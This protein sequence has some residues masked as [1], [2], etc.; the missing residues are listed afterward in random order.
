[1]RKIFFISLF[2][3]FILPLLHSQSY[4]EKHFGATINLRLN[5]GTHINSLGLGVSGYWQDFFVQ[6]NIQSNISFRLN[7]LGKRKHFWEWRNAFGLLLLGGKKDAPI[8]FQLEGLNHQTKFRYGIGYNYIIYTDNMGTSQHSG[9]F[10]VHI[11]QISVYHENDIFAGRVR[12]RFRTAHFHVSFRDSLYKVGIGIRLWTGETRNAPFTY[13]NI[14]KMKA[15]FK[16]L[17]ELPYGKTSHGIL[18]A[19][20][21]Y[22]LPYSQNAFVKVGIDSE[23]IRHFIQNRFIHDLIFLPDKFPRHSSHYPRL[24]K[25]GCA[26][27]NKKERRKDRFYFQIGTGEN[28]FE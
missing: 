7:D 21:V 14:G 13:R 2:F 27:F 16:I 28:R 20:G 6:S 3:F 4:L 23:E 17:E 26:T 5:F 15:G 10:G 25:N 22:H 12:D 19:S 1:M 11:N 18:Y 9:S 8:D 24:D